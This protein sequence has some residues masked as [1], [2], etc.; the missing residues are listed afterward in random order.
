MPRKRQFIPSLAPQERLHFFISVS[1]FICPRRGRLHSTIPVPR[2]KAPFQAPCSIST[3]VGGYSRLRRED[4]LALRLASELADL[5]AAN[6]NH[7][8]YGCAADAWPNPY[9]PHHARARRLRVG[10]LRG[11]GWWIRT[12]EVSDNRFTVCPLWPL[13]KSPIFSF[14]SASRSACGRVELAIGLEPATC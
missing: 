9:I 8:S 2:K 6:A 5:R 4:S 14:P 12:T 10:L 3:C 1:V 7:A 13:G 11:G